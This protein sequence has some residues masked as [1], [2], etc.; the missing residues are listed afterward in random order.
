MY[1]KDA[2]YI[3]EDT[4]KTIFR[5]NIDDKDP[6][7]W[8]TGLEGNNYHGRCLRTALDGAALLINFQT[9]VYA[10]D[11]E[12][13]VMLDLGNPGGLEELEDELQDFKA[14]AGC[15]DE[16]ILISG[17][18]IWGYKLD[19]QNFNSRLFLNQKIGLDESREEQACCLAVSPSGKHCLISTEDESENQARIVILEILGGSQATN[20]RSAVIK[21]SIEYKDDEIPGLSYSVFLTKKMGFLVFGGV[22]CEGT[23]LM[24]FAYSIQS[25]KVF[26]IEDEV[27]EQVKEFSIGEVVS[28]AVESNFVAFCGAKGLV[29]SLGIS[30][31]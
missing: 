19:F 16:V 29:V 24:L 7:V 2:Y 4:T 15:Q 25:G 31:A 10:F 20:Q 13:Q 17:G 1:T 23:D 22:D 11:V 3:Y 28:M 27:K 14:P 6:E 8:L 18:F 9:L 21:T 5:K 26:E 30:S 12:T